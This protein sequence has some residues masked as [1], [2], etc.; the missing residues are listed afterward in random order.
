M[1]D[2]LWEA[3]LNSQTEVVRSLLEFRVDPACKPSSSISR[4]PDPLR[5]PQWT[6]LVALAA[7]GSVER[8]QVV[9]ELLSAQTSSAELADET[10][11]QHFVKDRAEHPACPQS[12]FHGRQATVPASAAGFSGA[13]LTKAFA[14][15]HPNDMESY[16]ED[17]RPEELESL[18][19]RLEALLYAI[20]KRRQ[21]WL[22][23]RLESA[24]RKHDEACRGRQT[25]EE[26]QCC[27]VCSEFQKTVLFMP[28]RHLCTCRDCAAPLQLCPICRTSIEEKLHCIQP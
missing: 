4:P 18:E 21:Y 2:S 16:L 12:D 14:A 5:Y 10:V 6:P 26:E 28:C 3:A 11:A 24:Q 22:E 13:A 1:R 20:R 17:V 23:R 25:L 8:A 7:S 9:A 19:S 27:V 15:L